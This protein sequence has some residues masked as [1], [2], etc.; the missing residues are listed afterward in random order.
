VFAQ[1]TNGTGSGA[2]VYPTGKQ[3]KGSKLVETMDS[4]IPEEWAGLIQKTANKHAVEAAIHPKD[5][6]FKF[7]VTNPA[8]VTSNDA[9]QYYFDD[10][11]C[12]GQKTAGIIREFNLTEAPPKILEF[13]SGYGCVTRHLKKVFTDLVSC[14][15]HDEA[16]EFIRNVLGVKTTPSNRIPEDFA[17]Q[18]TFDVVFAL[19]FFSHLPQRTFG[20][21]L[22]ALFAAVK[23][24]GHLVFTTHG[25]A[26]RHFLGNPAIPEDG[27]WFLPNSEQEDLPKADYGLTIVTPEFVFKEVLRQTGEPVAVYKHAYWWNHQDLWIIDKKAEQ[28]S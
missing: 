24:P 23:S 16:M 18:D 19:S 6:I 12:S 2:P 13:A 7:V 28:V 4:V 22:K 20:R 5:F 26:S 15:I 14:D 25:T 27:F 21:W 17:A 10:G 11:A 9:I 8:F 1:R 3:G